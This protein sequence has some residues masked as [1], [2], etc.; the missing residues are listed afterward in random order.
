MD[1]PFSPSTTYR[2]LRKGFALIITL[3]VL[4]VLIALTGVL[5]GYLDTAREDASQTKALLQANLY[6]NDTKSIISKFKDRKTLYNI[7]YL[8]PLPLQS[9]DGKFSLIVSC[10]PMAN[11][12]NINWLAFSNNQ[13]MNRQYNAAAK[14]FDAL[15]TEYEVEDPTRLEEMI[16]EAVDTEQMQKREE[17][18]R[19]RQKN[20]IISYQQ[21][22]QILSR[23]QFESDDGHVGRIPWERYFV[24]N[25]VSKIPEENLIDGDFLSAELISVLFDMDI[26]ILKAEWTPEEDALKRL[27]GNNGIAYDN[28][29][30]AK[31]FLAQS[32]CEVVFEFDGERFKFAF[33]DS[34][35]EVKDFEFY[36]K[37]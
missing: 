36:G 14:V 4:S 15:V 10:R 28:K 9:E 26:E 19:L 32:R 2:P 16:L 18:S 21:F 31:G 37:Q 29:L 12:V 30:F 27:L 35:G 24:F 17:Q 22:K 25:P 20:G 3:S 13:V 5:V 1:K 11:G 7:L 6:Y 33:T 34:E 23:Y 8:S